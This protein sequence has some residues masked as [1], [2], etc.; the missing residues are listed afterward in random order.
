[1]IPLPRRKGFS[2]IE[3]VIILAIV[4]VLL[5]IVFPRL[6]KSSMTVVTQ[7][8][9][10]LAPGSSTPVSVRVLVGRKFPNEQEAIHFAVTE[11]GGT[12]SPA[13]AKTD[14][15]GVATTTWTLGAAPGTRNALTATS[16]EEGVSARIEVM[17]GPAP[18]TVTTP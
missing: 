9:A 7:P 15:A 4:A 17:T 13:E 12:V 1:M 8:A 2:V 14:S 3:L 6:M 16:K 10:G 18:G 11:G 5:A